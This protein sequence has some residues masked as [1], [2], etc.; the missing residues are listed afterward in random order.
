VFLFLFC[1][2]T[3]TFRSEVI[4]VVILFL[5]IIL[6]LFRLLSSF[7]GNDRIYQINQGYFFIFSLQNNIGLDR[8]HS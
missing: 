8:L 7:F 6:T 3:L 1:I 4:R 5:V 2:D